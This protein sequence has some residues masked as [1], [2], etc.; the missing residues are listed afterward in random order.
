MYAATLNY[1]YF[2]TLEYIKNKW[3]IGKCEQGKLGNK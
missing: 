3:S 1:W 2:G